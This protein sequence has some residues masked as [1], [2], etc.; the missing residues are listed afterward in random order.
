MQ[1]NLRVNGRL[2]NVDVNSQKPLLWVL[3]EGGVPPIA[4]AVTKAIFAATGQR[5]RKLPISHH[6][7]S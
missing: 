7:F 5:I 3:R 4:P 2:Y 6:T 1:Y